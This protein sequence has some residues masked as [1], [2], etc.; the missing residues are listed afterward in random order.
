MNI[1]A[2]T[3]EEYISKLPGDRKEAVDKLR[4]VF[5]DN[6]PA[7]FEETMY[8]GMIGFVVPHSTYP[9]GYHCNPED[10]LPFVSLASQKNHIALYH[11]GIYAFPELLEWFTSEYPKHVKTRLDMGK[12]CIRF[13][14]PERIPFDLIAELAGKITVENWIETYETNVK[15]R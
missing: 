4:Q 5:R 14:K 10:P 1:E 13:K 7:G 2:G 8:C 15:N 12:S 6:L 11:F 3:T 9:D